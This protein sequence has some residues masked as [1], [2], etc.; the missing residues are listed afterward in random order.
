[1]SLQRT[2]LTNLEG[3]PNGMAATGSLW[4]DVMMDDR[5]ASYSEFSH[6]LGKLEEKGQV[7]V[8]R[9]EDRSKAK[10]TDAGKLRLMER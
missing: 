2:I 3:R 6:A 4:T 8:I 7:L 1:M 9:G 10:I 5:G